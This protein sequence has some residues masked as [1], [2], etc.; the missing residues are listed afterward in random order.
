MS[1][2]EHPEPTRKL[3][4]QN[5]GR[6]LRIILGA[7]DGPDEEVR[8]GHVA[9]RLDVSPASVTE[10]TQHLSEAGYVD[11]EPYGGISLTERGASMARHLQWRQ[12]VFARFFETTLDVAVPGNASYEASFSMPAHVLDQAREY[13][14]LDCRDECDD[15]V[16][17][18]ECWAE[19]NQVADAATE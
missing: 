18:A 5:A 3:P 9:D 10:M 7:V 12:C 13:V 16:W 19:A 17:E 8:P 1:L 11:H 2:R 4:N 14:G 15:R 6:Y